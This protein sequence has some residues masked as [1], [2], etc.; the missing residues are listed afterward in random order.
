MGYLKL[1]KFERVEDLLAT[2]QQIEFG[3]AERYLE[4]AKA[5]RAENPEVSALF[6]RLAKE[7]QQH[8][9]DVIQIAK[10][11]SVDL[12][13]T[14]VPNHSDLSEKIEKCRTNTR[15]HV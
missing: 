8:E 7:E 12:P 1:I 10:D 6:E 5:A 3:A 2:A 11:A 4:S 9:K 13:S 14:A 15:F